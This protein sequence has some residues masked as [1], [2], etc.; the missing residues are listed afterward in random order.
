MPSPEFRTR[1][2][3]IC[4]RL[5]GAEVSDPWGGG[6][7]AW[8][9]GEKMFACIGAVADGVSVK[10]PDIETASMLKEMGVAR[11]APYFHKSWVRLG[12][13]A[14]INELE[15]RL[16]TRSSGGVHPCDALSGRRLR[17]R[18]RLSALCR[19]ARSICIVREGSVVRRSKHRTRSRARGS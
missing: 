3:G 1:I 17:L 8:K 4:E 5:P 16:V 10:T 2:N 19:A 6:H 12:E 11:N 9:I 15:A 13:D 7:D 18:V 14:D